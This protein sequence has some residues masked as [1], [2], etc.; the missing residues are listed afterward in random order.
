MAPARSKTPT[1]APYPPPSAGGYG[2]ANWPRFNFQT[3]TYDY[4]DRLWPVDPPAQQDIYEWG[5]IYNIDGQQVRHQKHRDDVQRA[6]KRTAAELW[7]RRA[8]NG[9]WTRTMESP[10]VNPMDLL[11]NKPSPT[12]MPPPPTFRPD[13]QHTTSCLPISR[14][15]VRAP[16]LTP[17]PGS[18]LK[19]VEAY[20]EQPHPASLTTKSTA[21]H[22]SQ[23]L[24][25]IG[26]NKAQIPIDTPHFHQPSLAAYSPASSASSTPSVGQVRNAQ[27]P[28][29]LPAFRAPSAM[30]SAQ[31]SH[32]SAAQSATMCGRAPPA[33]MLAAPGHLYGVLA[34]HVHEEN[35]PAGY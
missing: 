29:P 15:V 14:T 13:M 10:T 21:D 25:V 5:N 33:P 26:A 22:I 4:S 35:K 28:A 1:S 11:I 12:A 8:R 23:P 30:M 16:W 3:G 24:P 32:P 19:Q 27:I 34:P 20:S 6:F 18:G 9:A 2:F 17:Y 7:C 31:A